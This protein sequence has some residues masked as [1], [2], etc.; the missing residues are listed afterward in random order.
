MVEKIEKEDIEGEE[1]E[2]DQYLVSKVRSQEFGIQAMRV[3]EISSV[4]PTTA[5]P[6]APPYIEGILNLRGQ[7]ATVINFRKKFGFEGKE[8][9]EDT[10]IVIVEHRGFPIGII[11]DSVEEVIKVTEKSLRALPEEVTTKVSEDYITGVAMMEKRIMILLDAEKL[12]SKMELAETVAAGQAVQEAEG[13]EESRACKET[14]A[15]TR[16]EE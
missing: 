6:S 4:L 3:Q 12:L 10:R 2:Q 16:K 13:R 14:Q 9:D 7:L 8:S 11:V 5:V 15:E 1:I